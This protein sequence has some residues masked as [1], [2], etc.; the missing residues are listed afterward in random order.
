MQNSITAHFMN[1]DVG[2]IQVNLD[3]TDH[4]TTDF[5]TWRTICL[6]PVRCT[7]SIR[8]MYTTDFA[9]DGQ[10]FL[11]P[12]SLSYPSSPVVRFSKD[13][14]LLYYFMNE[15]GIHI[16][17]WRNIFHTTYSMN[18][19]VGLLRDAGCIHSLQ[20]QK[21]VCFSMRRMYKINK[22]QCGNDI[23]TLIVLRL[24]FPGGHGCKDF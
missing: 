3:M 8:H 6:V 4:C 10:I 19:I 9:Y 17:V 22:S 1:F 2:F 11:V 18:L 20:A 15:C 24:L 14:I 12:L 23:V 21:R 7:S 5:C 16:L 13:N